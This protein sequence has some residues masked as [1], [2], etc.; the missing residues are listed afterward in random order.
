MDQ[1]PNSR[2]VLKSAR[3]SAASLKWCLAVLSDFYA[4]ADD[5]QADGVAGAFHQARE[6]CTCLE[7]L[8]SECDGE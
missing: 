7:S 2:D 1:S 3:T 6:I 4:Q 8:N 5:P